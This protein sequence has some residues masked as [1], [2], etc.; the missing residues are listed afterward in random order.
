MSA[1]AAEDP[2]ATVEP[3]DIETWRSAQGEISAGACVAMNSGWTAKMGNPSWR[4]LPDGT[5]AFPSFSKAATD[6]LADTGEASIGVDALAHDP[7]NSADFAVHHSRL[8]SARATVFTGAPKHRGG[9]GGVARVMTL[10]QDARDGPQ[11]DDPESWTI[12]PPQIVRITPTGVIAAWD[13][14]ARFW[15][16]P[17]PLRRP[18]AMTPSA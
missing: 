5:L 10:L 11:A 15:R 18:P 6:L 4:N 17:R 1:K 14:A 13:W 7:G 12:R 2:N 9:T 3:D 16:M 8:P